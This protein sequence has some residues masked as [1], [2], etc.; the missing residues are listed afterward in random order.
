MLL[1]RVARLDPDDTALLAE[2]K[3]IEDRRR[4]EEK[5]RRPPPRELAT[6]HLGLHRVLAHGLLRDRQLAR[7]TE[8]QA[9]LTCCAGSTS[10]S[11]PCLKVQYPRKGPAQHP[12]RTSRPSQSGPMCRL[13]RT[14]RRFSTAS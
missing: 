11:N 8:L 6:A 1:S 14:R 2:A 7:S 12:R 5:A 4:A 10:F 9:L 3:A 13:R